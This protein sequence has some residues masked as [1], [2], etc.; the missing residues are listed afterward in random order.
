MVQHEM[1]KKE[2]ILEAAIN[3]F[4][5]KGFQE[6]KIEEIAR[7]ADVGKGT[8][9][10]YFASKK[11]LFAE[12]IK[13]TVEHYM[14]RVRGQLKT[15]VNGNEQLRLIILAHVNYCNEYRQMYR[16]LF[17]DH[18]WL[19]GDFTQWIITNWRER[20][21]GVQQILQAGIEQGEFGAMDSHLIAEALL[22]MVD[23]ICFPA[24]FSEIVIEPDDTT[25]KVLNLILTGISRS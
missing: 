9:Y 1:S 11:E 14:E 7:E 13:Y 22:G 23:G 18:S 2:A 3:V 16:V 12:M 21:T 4:V 24:I 20:V 17:Q 6:A 5:T 15:A 8:V 19:G 10:E 25:E